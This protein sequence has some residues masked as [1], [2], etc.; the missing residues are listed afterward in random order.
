MSKD[1]TVV[2]VP[3]DIKPYIDRLKDL[4]ILAKT[5]TEI[6]ALEATLQTIRKAT[7]FAEAIAPLAENN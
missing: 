7:T 1:S 2:R 5:D 3:N 6:D 4:R